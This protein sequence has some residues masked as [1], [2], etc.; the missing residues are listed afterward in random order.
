[1]TLTVLPESSL[2]SVKYVI[3]HGR[4]LTSITTRY[5][6]YNCNNVLFPCTITRNFPVAWLVW[7]KLYKHAWTKFII[8]WLVHAALG[9][10]FE[11]HFTLDS[12]KV[13]S[14]NYQMTDKKPNNE[15]DHIQIN[16]VRGKRET[17][18]KAWRKGERRGKSGIGTVWNLLLNVKE[19]LLTDWHGANGLVDLGVVLRDRIRKSLHILHSA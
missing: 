7:T 1:M 17:P 14:N 2:G 5:D 18:S 3:L 13:V 4:R 8:R 12:L 10:T 11:P 15:I 6:Y 16:R 9:G 19:N